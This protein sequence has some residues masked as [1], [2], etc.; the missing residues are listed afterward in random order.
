METSAPQIMR[1]AKIDP[2]QLFVLFAGERGTALCLKAKYTI[3]EMDSDEAIRV[4]PIHW[5]KNAESERVLAYAHSLDGWAAVLA[6]A[7]LEV[8]PRSACTLDVASLSHVYCSPEGRVF[9][10]TGRDNAVRTLVDVRSG[11]V[12]PHISGVFMAFSEWRIT[13][14]GPDGERVQVF[15]ETAAP[16]PQ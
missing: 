2:G 13:V 11:E 1:V 15:P 9:L 16:S 3:P 4:V 8:S 5:P 6:E 12:L 10:P 7:R 14:L